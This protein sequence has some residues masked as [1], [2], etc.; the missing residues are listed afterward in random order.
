MQCITWLVDPRIFINCYVLMSEALPSH[1]A[2][3]SVFFSPCHNLRLGCYSEET[4]CELSLRRRTNPLIQPETA[5]HYACPIV[6]I[7][8]LSLSLLSRIRLV[9]LTSSSQV[10]SNQ[11]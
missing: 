10:T 8:S 7:I 2:L 4:C 6:E 5:I 1:L 9:F 11:R 3:E